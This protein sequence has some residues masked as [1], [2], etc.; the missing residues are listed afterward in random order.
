VGTGVD[1][2]VSV[3]QAQ[4]QTSPQLVW[5]A[6]MVTSALC[7]RGRVSVRTVSRPSTSLRGVFLLEMGGIPV[8]P[9]V[10]VVR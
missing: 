7:E 1:Q 9:R 3:P 10:V 2:Y 5:S 8:A 4:V 6:T